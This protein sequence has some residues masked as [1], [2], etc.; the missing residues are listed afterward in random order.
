MI[1]SQAETQCSKCAEKHIL[2][3]YK[4]INVAESPSLKAKV[5]D[6]SL[7]LWQCP[8][9]GTTNLAAY[10]TLYH[11]PEKKIM[12]WLDLRNQISET[13]MQAI[14]NHTKAMG[15]YRLR[16]VSDVGSLIEKLH[17]FEDGL[18]DLAI[19]FCKWVTVQEMASKSDSKGAVAPPDPRSLHYH[20]REGEGETGVLCFSLA[21]KGN[22]SELRVGRNV[23]E[24]ACGIIERNPAVR[25]AEGFCKIDADYLDKIIK[26]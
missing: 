13:Q 14:S 16:L 4:S 5:A 8:H 17:I 20:R 7:F 22:M 18:D 9:C 25:P 12:L 24:D 23:Y 1:Q 2:T 6:G 19:E 10:D 11:D 15:G 3:I 26:G 21:D